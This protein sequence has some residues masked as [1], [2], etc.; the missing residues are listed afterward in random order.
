M[1]VHSDTFRNLL[2]E[3][4]GMANTRGGQSARRH[5]YNDGKCVCCWKGNRKWVRSQNLVDTA[6]RMHKGRCTRENEAHQTGTGDAFRI[7]A[8]HEDVAAVDN[9]GAA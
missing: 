6:V 8:E 5:I 3:I 4:S 7:I 2:A 1:V 9:C